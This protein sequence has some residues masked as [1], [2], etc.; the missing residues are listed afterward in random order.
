MA[1]LRSVLNWVL[2]SVLQITTIIYMDS[3]PVSKGSICLLGRMKQQEG[4]SS[5]GNVLY[6]CMYVLSAHVSALTSPSF[7][8]MTVRITCYSYV[9]SACYCSYIDKL[10][11]NLST[12]RQEF[13]LAALTMTKNR[14]DKS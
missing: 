7:H 14:I 5:F 10:L 12:R 6:V 8:R 1:V 3:S 13:E 2:L 11:R 9:T 4:L